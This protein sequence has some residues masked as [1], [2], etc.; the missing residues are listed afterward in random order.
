MTSAFVTKGLSTLGRK[1]TQRRVS[2]LEMSEEGWV[3]SWAVD[4]DLA[5]GIA[6]GLDTTYPVHPE[7]GGTSVVWIKR[8]KEGY[9]ID[10][11]GE[12]YW[13]ARKWT[14]Q[15]TCRVGCMRFRA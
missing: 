4:W 1:P 12:R 10:Y 7:K 6:T 15:L 5:T 13:L 3:A 8:T 14:W 2:D 9:L 11:Q